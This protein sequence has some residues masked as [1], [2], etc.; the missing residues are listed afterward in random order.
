VALEALDALEVVDLALLGV[1]EDLSGREGEAK[2]WGG[3]GVE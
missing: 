3:E 2:G 1:G